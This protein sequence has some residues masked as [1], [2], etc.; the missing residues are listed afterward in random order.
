MA[1]ELEV[2]NEYDWL[3][4]GSDIWGDCTLVGKRVQKK[5][6]LPAGVRSGRLGQHTHVRGVELPGQSEARDVQRRDHEQDEQ[7]VRNADWLRARGRQVRGAGP[8]RFH[9]ISIRRQG[10]VQHLPRPGSGQVP[11]PGPWAGR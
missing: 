7:R 4:P 6:Q 5:V 3:V 11:V 8:L 9:S 1:A 2:H 10:G